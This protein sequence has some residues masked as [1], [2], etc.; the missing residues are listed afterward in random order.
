MPVFLF[1]RQVHSTCRVHEF[2]RV[3]MNWFH[4]VGALGVQSKLVVVSS[5]QVR[6]GFARDCFHRENE[7][8]YETTECGSED[9]ATAPGCRHASAFGSR[10]ASNDHTFFWQ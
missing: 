9:A 3:G 8:K 10:S 2:R 4:K 7:Q 1:V 5:Y 6:S